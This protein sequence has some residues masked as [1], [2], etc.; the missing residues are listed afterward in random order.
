MRAVREE[1]VILIRIFRTFEMTIES[2]NTIVLSTALPDFLALSLLVIAPSLL[3]CK[4]WLS[5]RYLYAV[6]RRRRKAV[7]KVTTS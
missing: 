6:R 3:P 5:G 1:G 7:I 4:I 2:R